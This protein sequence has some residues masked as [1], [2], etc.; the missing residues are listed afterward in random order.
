MTKLKNRPLF[1]TRGFIWRQVAQVFALVLLLS[2]GPAQAQEWI[3]GAGYTDFTDRAAAD[4]GQLSLEYRH[5]PFFSQGRFDV[6]AAA[7]AVATFEGDLFLG[8]GL[9]G[10]Y[11][12]PNGWFVELSVMPG[13]FMEGVSVNDLGSAFEIRSLLG[14][15]FALNDRDSLSLAI[16]HKSNASTSS[17]NPGVNS[18]VLR[19]H[20]AF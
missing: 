10:R 19:Y 11:N 6:A 13:V 2:S 17:R 15:G 3:L 1:S 20:R 7:S 9:S 4:S 8:G 16:T 14:V 18:L 12:V 5:S